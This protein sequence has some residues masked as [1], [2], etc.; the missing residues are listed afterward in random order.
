MHSHALGGGS[1]N[2]EVAMGVKMLFNIAFAIFWLLEDQF[3]H[4]ASGRD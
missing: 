4:V 1:N 2:V 3:C